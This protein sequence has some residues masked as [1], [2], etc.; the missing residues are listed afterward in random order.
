MYDRQFRSGG[1]TGTGIFIDEASD[2][3][4]LDFKLAK[5][6]NDGKASIF[7]WGKDIFNTGVE[8][9]DLFLKI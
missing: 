7:I 3:F 2:K 4:R 6:F 9:L 1:S 8:R 5:K